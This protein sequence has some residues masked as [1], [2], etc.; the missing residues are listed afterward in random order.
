MIRRGRSIAVVVFVALLGASACSKE[1]VGVAPSGNTAQLPVESKVQLVMPI[2]QS[3]GFPVSDGV[4]LPVNGSLIVKL[5]YALPPEELALGSRLDVFVCVGGPVAGTALI[6]S[7]D[8]NGYRASGRDTFYVSLA[9]VLPADRPTET[10][11]LVYWIS[12]GFIASGAPS[13]PP[14]TAN[15][16]VRDYNQ[17][18]IQGELNL[19]V[20]WVP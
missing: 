2:T 20:Q 16:F 17:V 6:T 5:E 10:V 9:D 19:R 4:V 11:R 15:Y 18:I 1:G 13:V 3:N 14:N 7:C 12:K 8:G